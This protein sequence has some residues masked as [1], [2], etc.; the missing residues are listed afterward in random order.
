MLHYKL[1]LK[2]WILGGTYDIRVFWMV[3]FL[4]ARE[5]IVVAFKIFT[6]T[7]MRFNIKR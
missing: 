5:S 2:F 1:Y 7:G 6:R 3:S 4:R